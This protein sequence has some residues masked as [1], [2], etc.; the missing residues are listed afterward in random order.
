MTWPEEIREHFP[1]WG[2]AQAAVGW[3]E[4]RS[5]LHIDQEV[6][7]TV[8]ARAPFG[9][10]LDIGVR[11]PALLLVPNMSGAKTRRITFDEY[12]AIGESIEARVQA[13]GDRGEIG[14]TQERPE[15]DPWRDTSEFALGTEFVRPVISV[16]NYGRFVELKPGVRALLRPERSQG[17]LAVGDVV[18]VRVESV[19]PERETVEVA[20]VVP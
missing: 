15:D 18:R 10:W 11:F 20:Q 9:V 19:D 14:L 7:G 16:M 6:R 17:P 4:V 2:T 8:I 3:P 12:P 13:L 1:N 5:T